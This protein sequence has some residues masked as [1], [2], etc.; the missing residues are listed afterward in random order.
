[1]TYQVDQL[2]GYIFLCSFRPVLDPTTSCKN[3]DCTTKDANG[4][5]NNDFLHTFPDMHNKDPM[6]YPEISSVKVWKLNPSGGCKVG[7]GRVLD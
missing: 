2:S 1:M 3:W 4:N 6:V 7:R 5:I